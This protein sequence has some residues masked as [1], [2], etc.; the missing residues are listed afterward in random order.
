MSQT[1]FFTCSICNI[2]AIEDWQHLFFHCRFS[3][4]IWNH[5]HITWARLNAME[6]D[7]LLHLLFWRWFLL[8]ARTFGGKETMQSLRGCNLL[9][10]IGKV[11]LFMISLSICIE[12]R[13][14]L[15]NICQC[16]L[17]HFL[18]FVL[19]LLIWVFWIMYICVHCNLFLW[20]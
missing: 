19:V 14:P 11:P 7:I 9:S 1:F 13:N 10:N 12:W 18:R 16:E 20:K 17:T 4:R 3:K 15:P 8:H 5:L 6:K 2:G